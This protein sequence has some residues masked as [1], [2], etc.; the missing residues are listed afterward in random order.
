MAP[1][2]NRV[3]RPG[4]PLRLAG[5]TQSM[6]GR[7]APR[8]N[9]GLGLPS[10]IAGYP[11]M[12]LTVRIVL[13]DAEPLEFPNYGKTERILAMRIACASSYPRRAADVIDTASGVVLARF[14][15]GWLARAAQGMQHV[16]ALVAPGQI[17]RHER[18]VAKDPGRLASAA[19]WWH[20][21]RATV[22][23]FDDGACTDPPGESCA[24]AECPVHGYPDDDDRTD[25]WDDQEEDFW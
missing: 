9:A 1:A 10:G 23:D 21:V 19:E 15:D 24:D 25:P 17:I 12:P 20:P 5:M 3:P 11:P 2:G 8:E 4:R 13:S 18:Q 16:I 7:L 22:P 6:P 14:E